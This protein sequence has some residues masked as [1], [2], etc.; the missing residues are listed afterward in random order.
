MLDHHV[1]TIVGQRTVDVIDP[2]D[3][4]EKVDG[5]SDAILEIKTI[6]VRLECFSEFIDA[7]YNVRVVV[8]EFLEHSDH[9]ML[10]RVHETLWVDL[11]FAYREQLRG[12]I[13]CACASEI[14]TVDDGFDQRRRFD[15]VTL[16]GVPSQILIVLVED[17]DVSLVLSF[18]EQHVLPLFF[19]LFVS[20][21]RCD[22]TGGEI[23]QQRHVTAGLIML[24]AMFQVM[25]ESLVNQP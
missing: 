15:D 18:G 2:R 23:K 7:L 3:G 12:V 13:R 9:V 17:D 25:I 24:G 5:I 6:N 20:F 22:N 19:S 16:W 14:V 11:G 21:S 8:R 4:V 1:V 10:I